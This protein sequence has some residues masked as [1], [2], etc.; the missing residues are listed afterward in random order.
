MAN[1]IWQKTSA[2]KHR[3][4]LMRG[5]KDLGLGF[6]EDEGYIRRLVRQGV[7]IMSKGRIEKGILGLALEAKIGDQ[8]QSLRDLK[9]QQ[10]RIRGE[11][12]SVYGNELWPT[13]D[14]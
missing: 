13:G 7:V 8:S 9:D 10:G 2:T 3:L 4:S 12:A 1:T 11:M 5:M 14:H 6:N